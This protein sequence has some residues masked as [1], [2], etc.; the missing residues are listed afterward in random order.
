VVEAE[1][2][3]PEQA[4]DIELA[5]KASVS[6]DAVPETDGLWVHMWAH[7]TGSLAGRIVVCCNWHIRT[8][9][10]AC[11]L[12]VRKSCLVVGPDLAGIA[13]RYHISHSRG[14]SH[15]L[16]FLRGTEQLPR[17]GLVQKNSCP[18][19]R[20]R[21]GQQFVRNSLAFVEPALV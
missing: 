2:C 18:S 12:G 7:R 11:N 21:F 13:L 14:C 5:Q 19:A 9:T 17:R 8:R 6:V 3:S 16:S 20:C 15:C 10:G 1:E 4:A